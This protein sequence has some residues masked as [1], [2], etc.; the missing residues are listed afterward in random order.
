MKRL[1]SGETM[2][3]LLVSLLVMSSTCPSEQQPDLES[4]V[5][6]NNTFALDLYSIVKKESGNLFL[7]PYSISSALAMTYGGAR[8]ETAEEMAKALRFELGPDR[9][10]PAF[11]ELDKVFKQIQ[12]KGQVKL[13]IANSLWPQKGHNFLPDYLELLKRYYGVSITPLDYVTAAE[14]ARKVINRWVED[15]TNDRIKDLIRPGDL[16]SI[17]VLVLVNAIYFK[18]NWASQFDPNITRESDFHLPG[19]QQT[20]VPMMYQKGNFEYGEIDGAKLLKLPYVGK[21]LSMVII[22]PETLGG[23][24]QIEDQ[25]TTENL[26]EWFSRISE[27]DVKV[28]LPKFKFTWGT[29]ELNRPLQT[30]GMCKAF[31]SEADFSGMDGTRGLYIG[32]VLH[33]A[34]IEVNEEGTEAAA[35]TAVI[36]EKSIPKIPVFKADHPFLF[37][38]RDN[39]TGSILFLGRVVDPSRG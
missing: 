11:A 15:K 3:I 5:K 14:Q 30:L 18:G 34:F 10:H 33:K 28:Y 35:A 36:M 6:G 21:E 12:K 27:Q 2:G 29:F 13:H 32:L 7:S 39:A 25:L 24:S 16:K 1:F 26:D 4:A 37:F 20:R 9:T 31:G 8:G 22:L 19:D 38:I 23:I 17:T